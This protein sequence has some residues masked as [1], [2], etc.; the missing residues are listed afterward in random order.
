[1]LRKDITIDECSMKAKEQIILGID[2][3]TNIMGYGIIRVKNNDLSL[4]TMGVLKFEK[5]KDQLKRLKDIFEGVITIIDNYNPDN[6]AIEAPFFMMVFCN[7]KS[8]LERGYLSF[9]NVTFG[10]INT[11]SSIS[12]PSHR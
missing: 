2:P 3:G 7:V 10:P 4:V 11:S 1:M 6:V 5:Q 8:C 12:T 9:V